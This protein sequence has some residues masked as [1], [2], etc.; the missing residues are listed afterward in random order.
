MPAADPTDLL[1]RHDGLIRRVAWVY[2]RRAADRDELA[3]EIAVQVWRA[4]PRFD[5][6]CREST[7]I[8]RIALNV[9][10]SFA[11]RE[12]RRRTRTTTLA[13]PDDVA[14]APAAAPSPE[15]ERLL[16][17]IATL[18]DLD[19]ALVLMHLDGN[20]HA[21]IAEALGLS[22]SNVG[23]RLHR[24]RNTVRAAFARTDARNPGSTEE[25]PWN[26]TT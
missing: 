23:T 17:V 19:R 21:G 9:A 7:W 15:V 5:G 11:R 26:S 8:Y 14:A 25:R 6:R 3:Q 22:A 20:D 18:G 2:A 24:I 4:A 16:A 1:R 13:A 12:R 10:I